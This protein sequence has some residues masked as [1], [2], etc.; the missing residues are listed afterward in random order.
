MILKKQNKVKVLVSPKTIED[1]TKY[2]ESIKK[3]NYIFKRESSKNI[4]NY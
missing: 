3:E 1:L 2:V 4:E